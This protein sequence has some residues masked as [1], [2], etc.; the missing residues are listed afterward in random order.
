MKMQGTVKIFYFI[1]FNYHY[2]YLII[3]II[4]NLELWKFTLEF[5][6]FDDISMN[7]K[8]D[9]DDSVQPKDFTDFP[10]LI[11]ADGIRDNVVIWGKVVNKFDIANNKRAITLD[12]DKKNIVFKYDFTPAEEEANKG[13]AIEVHNP[14]ITPED[15]YYT[16][17]L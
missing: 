8:T 15:P 7:F 4:I 2:H 13:N 6:P 5:P 12:H 1:L 11:G 9:C 16:L 3:I 10:I 17:L 14:T